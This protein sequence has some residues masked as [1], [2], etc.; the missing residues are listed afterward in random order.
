MKKSVFEGAAT[1]L[2]TPFKNGEIDFDTLKNNIEWQIKEGIDALCVCGT[3]GE[4]ASMS[5]FEKEKVIA[6]SAEVINKRVPLIAGTGSC[7][8][9]NSLALTRF[10]SS[11]GADAVLVVTPYYNKGNGEAIDKSF[12]T[13]A[14]GGGISLIIY[15]VPSRTGYDMPVEQVLRLSTHP[16]ICGIKE[17]CGNID[18]VQRLTC[19]LPDDFAV[20]SGNDSQIL[21]IYSLG[22]KGVISVCSNIIPADTAKMCKACKQEKYTE[23]LEIAK[24]YHTLISLLFA[25]VNPAPL[26]CAMAQLGI[27]TG[28]LRLPLGDVSEAL[29]GKLKNE[30]IKLGMLS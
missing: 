22:G 20:Y 11:N 10:A 29:Y 16:L 30:L 17:A 5:I 6:F 2:V 25:E 3:T 23:A 12:Y 4:N 15:N 24:R 18:K 26:K 28:E 1:A 13:I 21:P 8:I 9:A 19:A 7:N 27:D 14:E